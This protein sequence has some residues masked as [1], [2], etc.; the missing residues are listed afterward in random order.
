MIIQ[1]YLENDLV[2]TYSDQGMYIQGGSPVG[3]Y[4]EA[5]DPKEKILSG[6]RSYIETNILIPPPEEQEEQES[7]EEES[8]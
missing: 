3:T 2:L 6:E 7:Q 5:I 4:T 1:E 8:E